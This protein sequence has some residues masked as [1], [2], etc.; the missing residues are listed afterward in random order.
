[1][2]AISIEKLFCVVIVECH[3]LVIYREKDVFLTVLELGVFKVKRLSSDEELFAMSPNGK[4][5]NLL[6]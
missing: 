5:L 4:E 6:L 3:H 2:K 1:V